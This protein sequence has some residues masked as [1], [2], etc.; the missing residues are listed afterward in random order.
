MLNDSR[1]TNVLIKLALLS[2]ISVIL[3]YIAFPIIPAFNWL[4]IDFSDIPALIGAF[5]YGPIYGI[6]IEG[7]KIGIT[8]LIRGSITGGIGELANFIIGS[9]FV[10]TA[11]FVY[12]KEQ[13]RINAIAAMIIAT[14]AM[15]VTALLTNYF[16]LIPL[17]RSFVTLLNNSDYV[18][19]YLILGVIPF[20]L[21]K[22]GAV[23]LLTLMVYKSISNLLQNEGVNYRKKKQQ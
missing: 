18:I 14:I 20:N 19:R 17:Y 9:V 13:S 10:A 8:L 6:L 2:A 21:I 23:S 16:I 3:M 7:I 5:A 22:G 11:G 4:W 1:T 15:I 12:L